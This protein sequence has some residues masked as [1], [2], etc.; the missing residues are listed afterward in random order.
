M[1]ELKILNWF[2]HLCVSPIYLYREVQTDCHQFRIRNLYRNAAI[3]T[4][5]TV[6]SSVSACLLVFSDVSSM[7]SSVMG[8]ITLILYAER[9]VVGIPI[10]IWALAHSRALV[11][12]SNRALHIE[13]QLSFDKSIKVSVRLVTQVQLFF[14]F[15]TFFFNFAFQIYYMIIIPIYRDLLHAVV[16]FAFML[17]ES[18]ILVHLT[19]TQYWPV[20]LS[21][22]YVKLTK[23]INARDRNILDRVIALGSVLQRLKQ[24]CASVFGLIQFFHLL[25]IFVTCSV[26]W[27]I[28]LYVV[29][30][31]MPF[32]GVA[33][34]FY[35]TIA[36]GTSFLIYTYAHDRINQK[37]AELK[38]ALKSM[39]YR[40]LQKQ[41][42]D[43]KDFYD[44][45]NLKLMMASPKI[46]ACG[47]FEINLQIFYNV[48]HSHNRQC[49]VSAFKKSFFSL[50]LDRC[51]PPS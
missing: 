32:Y 26:E 10:V 9:L 28:V 25:N 36:Y 48:R 27:Y 45:V 49:T 5:L 2:N 11:D 38:D 50:S 13:R 1:E 31:G 24:Q 17:L 51:L 15:L 23:L 44:L 47:L 16:L 30:V 14:A 42:R 46:T 41:T 40:Q 22:R 39:Q 33:F 37:E 18:V 12:I 43:Q 29:D 34:K 8:I 3:L 21:N 20:F 6:T 4:T 7:L 35:T 19:Y